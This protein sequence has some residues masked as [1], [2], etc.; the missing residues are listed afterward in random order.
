M[1]AIRL[2]ALNFLLCFI[3]TVN[4]RAIASLR[5][6]YAFASDVTYFFI[7]YT[8]LKRIVKS[9]HF[10]DQA[11]YALGGATGAVLAM[12]VTRWF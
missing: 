4:W 10:A 5:Y 7:Q 11:A 12:W 8:T 6:E 1:N 2:F 3:V 9:D